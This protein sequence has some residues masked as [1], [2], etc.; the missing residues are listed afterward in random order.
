MFSVL[1]AI[2]LFARP[3]R[4]Y[5]I[6]G[7]FWRADWAQFRQIFRIGLPIAGMM[8]LESGLFMTRSDHIACALY[9]AEECGPV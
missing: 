4:R 8:L 5:S 1:L 2:A 9:K 7:R 3:F 6:L